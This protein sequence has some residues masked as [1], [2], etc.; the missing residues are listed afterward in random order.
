MKVSEKKVLKYL[1]QDSVNSDLC[2]LHFMSFL[3]SCITMELKLFTGIKILLS[4]E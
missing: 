2:F 3:Q 1:F 4:A